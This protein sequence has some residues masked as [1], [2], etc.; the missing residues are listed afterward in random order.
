MIP[1]AASTETAAV[2]TPLLRS[3][4]PRKWDVFA[5]VAIALVTLAVFFW[6]S[7]PWGYHLTN[8]LLHVTA[9]VLFYVFLCPLVPSARAAAL[10]A[11]IFAVH[12]LRME[13]VSL[14][15]QRKTV[16]A[17]VL[18]FLTLVIASFVT[19]MTMRAN[20]AVG[21]V[22]PLHGGNLL[23]H[24][25]MVSRVVVEDIDAVFLPLHLSP[26]YYYPRDMIYHPVKAYYDGGNL[27]NAERELKIALQLSEHYPDTHLYL[28]KVYAGRGAVALAR[29][30]L[31]R[32]LELAPGDPEGIE[33][34]M[35]I[36]S[37]DGA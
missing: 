37:G 25:L 10:A 6:G 15:V 4:R 26:I 13:A 24:L 28:A 21:A 16:L 18:W 7:D 29:T 33:L 2:E 17:G 30:H 20:A 14:A 5:A 19:W 1:Q 3:G 11:A 35:T 34:L 8:V 27:V 9:A 23:V 36:T 31:Q 12:P 32:F 22:H